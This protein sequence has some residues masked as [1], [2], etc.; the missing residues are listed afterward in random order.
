[1]RTFLNNLIV[2]TCFLTFV[3]TGA[4]LSTG[5]TKSKTQSTLHRI[6][7]KV[8]ENDLPDYVMVTESELHRF[9]AYD[10]LWCNL[11]THRIDGDYQYAMLCEMGT[12]YPNSIK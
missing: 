6:E 4:A 1:M 9:Q 3:F 7:V 5:C 2:A 10:R 12:L 8:L 11:E